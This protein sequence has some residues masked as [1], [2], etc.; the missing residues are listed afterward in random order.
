MQDIKCFINKEFTMSQEQYETGWNMPYLHFHNDYE[1][2]FLESGIRTV[3]IDENEYQTRAGDATLF[4]PNH[5]HGSRGETAFSGI[6]IHFSKSYLNRY[7]TAAAQKMLLACFEM[8]RIALPSEKLKIIKN[9]AGSFVVSDPNNFM[10]LG[11]ILQLLSQ[12]GQMQDARNDESSASTV[13]GLKNTKSEQILIYVKENYTSIHSVREISDLFEVNESYI[14]KIFK[15]NYNQTPKEYINE[16]RLKNACYRLQDS[17][18]TIASISEECGYLSQEYF[19]RLFKKKK[20]VTPSE[21]RKQR[22][23]K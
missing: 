5:L 1:I 22:R 12:W 11:S 20:G 19:T 23:E 4:L 10:I 7:F 9:D 13:Y 17:T 14:F 21:Y 16:L 18:R 2:Y 8:P 3:M 15:Q 6:C